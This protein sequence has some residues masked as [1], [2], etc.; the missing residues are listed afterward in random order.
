[1]FRIYL[2]AFTPD[3]LVPWFDGIA[4]YAVEDADG[5]MHSSRLTDGLLLRDEMP[6]RRAA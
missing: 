6:V 3:E 2:Q 1:V 5:T 4:S